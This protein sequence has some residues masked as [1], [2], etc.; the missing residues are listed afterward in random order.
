M[1]AFEIS[2][3]DT[4]NIV[5]MN[6]VRILLPQFSNLGNS[7]ICLLIKLTSSCDIISTN[8]YLLIK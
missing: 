4:A 3:G 7:F 1:V 2:T 8:V 5:R 6:S